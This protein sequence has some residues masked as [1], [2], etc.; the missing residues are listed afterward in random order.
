LKGTLRFFALGLTI[1][2]ALWDGARWAPVRPQRAEKKILDGLAALQTSHSGHNE[3][4][5][6]K[7]SV[8]VGQ[9]QLDHDTKAGMRKGYCTTG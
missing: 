2:R 9:Q 7:A 6:G 8:V 4:T 3:H 1:F 5:K